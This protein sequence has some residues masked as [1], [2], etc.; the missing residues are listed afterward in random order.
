MVDD[1]AITTQ[2]KAKLIADSRTDA[3]K[4]NVDTKQGVVQLTGFVDNDNAKREAG[5]V[6][7]S[8]DGVKDVRNDLEIRQ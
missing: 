3:Y 8:V 5:E 2:V 1:G 6:A 7:R 4:I